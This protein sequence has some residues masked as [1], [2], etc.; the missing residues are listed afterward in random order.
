MLAVGTGGSWERSTGGRRAAARWARLTAGLSRSRR[1]LVSFRARPSAVMNAILWVL[2]V[3][4]ALVF[5]ASGG[6]K[7]VK[8][9]EALLDTM[10][11]LRDYRPV[12]VKLI[13]LAEVLGAVGLIVPLAVGVA[14]GLV[15][16]AA[17][18]LASVVVGAAVVHAE[19]RDYKPLAVHAVLLVMAIAVVFGRSAD[20]PL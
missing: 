6:L 15:P 7:L 1:P 16:W 2:Q 9:K 8:P 10:A 12:T 11:V 18:G 17:L 20:I 13:G 14:P 3:L 4:L 19:H 5:L